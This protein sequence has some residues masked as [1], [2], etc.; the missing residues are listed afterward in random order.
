MHLWMKHKLFFCHLVVSIKTIA[1]EAKYEMKWNNK[2]HECDEIARIICSEAN[3]TVYYIWG[4]GTFGISFYEFFCNKINIEGFIDSQIRK[5]GTKVCGLPVHSPDVLKN[6]PGIVLVSTG[7]TKDVFEK[8][9]E[10]GYKKNVDCFHVDD[11]SSLYMFYKEGKVHL[12]DLQYIVTQYCTLHCEK[13]ASLIP[14]IKQPK[15]AS[16]NQIMRDLDAVFQWVDSVNVLGLVGGDAMLNPQFEEILKEIAEKY[17]PE[18][19]ACIEVYT[20]AVVVPSP[21]CLELMKKYNVFYRFT[22]YRPYTG[23]RQKIEQVIGLLD[24]EGIRY[25]HVQFEKWLD[26]GYPQKNNGILGEDNLKTFFDSCDR[27]SCHSLYD[28][29]VMY[30]GMGLVAEWAGYCN[31]SSS[32]YFDIS[33]YDE[34]RRAEF[35]EFMLGY[36]EK[37]YLSYC[38]KCNGGFNVNTRYIPAGKQIKQDCR[39]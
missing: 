33:Q 26:C 11:F 27:R 29:K 25:D 9:R 6:K 39:E 1:K 21:S 16:L 20:N 2:G 4:A 7:R 37:G 38:A 32:D 14:Y 34:C 35:L 15:H 23:K 10:I 17:Y 8:L 31:R 30:C 36:S 19:V 24:R 3:K 12:C 22:D 13:C 5:Q 18:R 28:Q